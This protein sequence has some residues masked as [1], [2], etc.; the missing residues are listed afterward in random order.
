MQELADYFRTALGFRAALLVRF[1]LPDDPQTSE[2]SEALQDLEEYCKRHDERESM[3]AII[4]FSEF[5]V[6]AELE[7]FRKLCTTHEREL[8][9]IRMWKQCNKIMTTIARFL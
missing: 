9:R 8:R 6:V 3:A 1:G 5:Y 7:E 2:A 4:E